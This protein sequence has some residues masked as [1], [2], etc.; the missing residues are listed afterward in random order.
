VALLGWGEWAGDIS[1][2]WRRRHV[3]ESGGQ[4]AVLRRWATGLDG[5][6]GKTGARDN[7]L[8]AAIHLGAE[9]LQIWVS[10]ERSWKRGKHELTH[11]SS[12]S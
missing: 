7:A 8:L 9:S 2:R 3:V 4:R 5:H 1:T 10:K 6:L 12:Y 11:P